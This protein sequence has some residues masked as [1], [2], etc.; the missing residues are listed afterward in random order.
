M[1]QFLDSKALKPPILF[2]NPVGGGT[3]HG[4]PAEVLEHII[5]ASTV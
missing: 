1:P 3:A 4:Y 2:Q 5:A